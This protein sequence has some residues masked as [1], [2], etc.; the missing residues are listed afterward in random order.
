[1][2]LLSLFL[3]YLH[4]K[5]IWALQPE[6]RH[7]TTFSEI[8]IPKQN[9]ASPRSFLSK[10]PPHCLTESTEC[11]PVTLSKPNRAKGTRETPGRGAAR[12]I[13]ISS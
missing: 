7:V 2:A 10:Q 1:M 8:L 4:K 5:K 3:G 13:N 12:E 6:K 9:E 11:C